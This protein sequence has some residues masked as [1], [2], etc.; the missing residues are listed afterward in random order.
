MCSTL[1]NNPTG[2]DCWIPKRDKKSSVEMIQYRSSRDS[3]MS[4][5]K[6][7]ITSLL[8]AVSAEAAGLMNCAVRSTEEATTILFLSV[9]LW[10]IGS[11]GLRVSEVFLLQL[12]DVSV[13]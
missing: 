9:S 4:S 12:L 1:G 7:L 5:S 11:T 10:E 2:F 6:T 13:I 8:H 3:P